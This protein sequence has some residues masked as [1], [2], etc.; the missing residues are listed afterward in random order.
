MTPE[1]YRFFSDPFV[2]ACI[3]VILVCALVI[4][5]VLVRSDTDE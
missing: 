1:I 5:L 2:Q 3:L 4:G